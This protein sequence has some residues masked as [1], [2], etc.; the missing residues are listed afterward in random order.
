MKIPSI[1]MRNIKTATAV[2][3]CLLLFEFVNRESS[4]YACIAAVICMQNTIVNSFKKGIERIIGTVIGGVAG[5][6]ILFIVTSLGRDELLIFIIPLGIIVLIEICVSIDMRQSVV[7]CSVVYLIILVTKGHEDSYVM[8]TFNRVLD[9]TLGILIALL[10]NKY[11]LLPDRLKKVLKFNLSGDNSGARNKTF[12]EKT[13]KLSEELSINSEE[14]STPH[15][16]INEKVD[17]N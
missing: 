2:F 5:I 13:D 6:I 7:I 16:E 14:N 17:A 4:I 12:L 10:V 3:M 8:Y 11:M 15:I 9:T 1:G